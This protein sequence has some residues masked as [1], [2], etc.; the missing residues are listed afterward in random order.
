MFGAPMPTGGLPSSVDLEPNCPPVY[1]QGQLGSCTG[2]AL[3]FAVQYERMRQN[4]TDAERVPSRLMIYYLEREIEGTINSDSGAQGYDGLTA[5]Q[6]TG[7]CYEDGADGWPYDPAQYAVRP[8]AACY[9]AAARDKVMLAYTV[10]QDINQ[11]RA[12]LAAGFPFCYG[13]TVYPDLDSDAVAQS[14][15]LPMPAP[16][17]QDIGGHEVVA[18]GHDDATRMFK[19]RNSWGPN[20][21]QR[22]Y[23]WM[24]YEY[25]M[26]QDLASE[27]LTMRLVEA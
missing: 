11:M 10:P 21:A 23:F 18:V 9:A 4:L 22:G 16:S 2:N 6:Q 15:V 25:L 5:L 20:W 3:A 7:V 17:A 19:V 8:P 12:C 26:R 13:F 27:M 24:P 1:D 14:G